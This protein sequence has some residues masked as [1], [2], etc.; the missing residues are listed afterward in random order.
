MTQGRKLA[1]SLRRNFAVG[2]RTRRYRSGDIHEQMI[3]ALRNATFYPGYYTGER[4]ELF[5]AAYGL[6]L[7]Y[8]KHVSGYR[9]DGILRASIVGLTPWHFAAL[10][11][12]MLDAG[13]R[14]TGDGERFFAQ[15]SAQL[16]QH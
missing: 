9:I 3:D 15:L 14:T 8:E 10:L 5:T 1:D 6:M 12:K 4:N 16:H 2:P 11:G 13:V 7:A